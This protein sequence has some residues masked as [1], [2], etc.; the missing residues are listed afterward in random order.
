M[1]RGSIGDQYGLPRDAV[2]H[3]A[4]QPDQRFGEGEGAMNLQVK[5][6]SHLCAIFH[7]P[8][9]LLR[10]QYGLWFDAR[11]ARAAIVARRFQPSRSC[12]RREVGF[13]VGADT[14]LRTVAKANCQQNL[15]RAC[16]T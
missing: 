5:H 12:A 6:V 1:D 8:S 3:V 9:Y 4:D 10:Q 7:R 13:R 15:R 11:A 14:P 16:R 2:C